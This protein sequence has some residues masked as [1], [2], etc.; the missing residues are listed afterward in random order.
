MADLQM[1]RLTAEIRSIDEKN[2]RVTAFVSTRS[3]DRHRTIFLPEAYTRTLPLYLGGNPI[4]LW[5]H[6]WH[7]PPTAAMG[8]AIDG[9]VVP[10]QGLELTFEY[11]VAENPVAA[12]V[13]GLVVKKVIRAFSVGVYILAEVTDRSPKAELDALPDYARQALLSGECDAVYTEVELVEFSQ[14]LIGSNR[15]SLTEAIGEGLVPRE[16]AMRALAG[17]QLEHVLDQIVRSAA[18]L[19]T[20]Q[21][22]LR[23]IGGETMSADPNAGAP[24]AAKSRELPNPEGRM[25]VESIDAGNRLHTAG[26]ILRV[27]KWYDDD[28]QDKRET[29]QGLL[30]ILGDVTLFVQSMMPSD[31]SSGE[32]PATTAG[33]PATRAGKAISTANAEKL[34]DMREKAQAVLK[35]IDDILGD[36]EE[37]E[38]EETAAAPEMT[39]AQS[40]EL[41]RALAEISQALKN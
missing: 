22:A 23:Q 33:A 26:D 20:N 36:D 28:D 6:M 39:E 14:V 40:A 10:M 32:Q 12:L 29:C 3:V 7:G 30:K 19:D 5:G 4:F 41:A 11:A 13:W 24:P 31:D 34:R 9:R 1:R 15:E 37:D 17:E 35:H 38:D 16:F 25:P 21:L 8:T 18:A 27:C 2:H